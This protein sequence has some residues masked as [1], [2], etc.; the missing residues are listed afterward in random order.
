M[1]VF[2]FVIGILLTILGSI[3]L[4]LEVK[5]GVLKK[6][7]KINYAQANITYAIVLVIILGIIFIVRSFK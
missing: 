1:D 2:N 6:T 4:Y 3:I 5:D 7:T